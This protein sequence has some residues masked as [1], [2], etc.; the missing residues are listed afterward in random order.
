MIKQSIPRLW[1]L[2]LSVLALLLVYSCHRPDE[3][4]QEY[5]RWSSSDPLAMPYRLRKQRYEQGNLVL[6]S[7]FELGKV[8]RFDTATFTTTLDAWDIIGEHVFWEK[9]PT[10]SAAGSLVTHY[11]RIERNNA[12]ETESFGEGIL[13]DYI[14]VLPGNYELTLRVNLNHIVNP[15]SRTGTGIYDAVDL[16]VLCYDRNKVQLDGQM[17]SP[18][19]DRK[20]DNNFKGV[21]FASFATIDSTGW[22]RIHGKTGDFPFQDGDLQDNARFVRIFI[23]LKGAGTML[24]DD[25]DFRYT[26]Y[27]FTALERI[28]PYFD[29]TLSKQTL[30]LPE[31][32]KME[33]LQSLTYY[34]P[35]YEDNFPIII[36][37]AQC[38]E[39][40]LEAAG[41]LEKKIKQLIHQHTELEE[42]DIPGL[43]HR[44]VRSFELGGALIF[45]IGTTFLTQQYHNEL[46]YPSIANKEKGYFIHSIND[47][48]NIILIDATTSQG[49]VYAIRSCIQLFDRDKL[50]FHNANIIDYPAL[51]HYSLLFIH[52]DSAHAD[53]RMA[54]NTRFEEVYLPASSYISRCSAE[55]D[56]YCTSVYTDAIGGEIRPAD[57]S[58][59]RSA[60]RGCKNWLYFDRSMEPPLP[61]VMATLSSVRCGQGLNA[62]PEKGSFELTLADED[63]STPAPR[64]VWTA[65]G[66]QTWKLDVA[67]WLS[68][69][70]T[71]GSAP[72]FADFSLLAR[73][74]CMGYFAQDSA[75]PYKLKT[76][77]LFDPF[78]NQILPELYGHFNKVI[79]VSEGNSVWDQIRLQTASDFFWNPGAYNPDLSVYRALVNQ[80]GSETAWNLLH[81][82]HYYFKLR[83]EIILASTHRANKYTRRVE[84]FLNQVKGYQEKLTKTA[85]ANS[86]LLQAVSEKVLESEGLIQQQKLLI[87]TP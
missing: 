41:L 65:S 43:I 63:G 49:I 72:V 5:D 85:G 16:K 7:S 9:Q 60:Y 61:E 26:R 83:A 77:C 64:K 35:F 84:E 23:G 40:T 34:R 4:G 28:A 1:C 82:N 62:D 76:A 31:P 80:F 2:V 55:G 87:S 50:V 15:K 66:F 38:D 68:Y 30:V 46:P 48:N 24:V 19:Y 70:N 79:V 36:I 33:V 13:S 17:Y 27:N 75:W 59:I 8:K 57:V 45:S 18:N 25:V 69:S 22:I 78:S 81:F 73:S 53:R 10:D 47:Q 14:K 3:I 67:E 52:P 6:N 37:P 32:Q 58:C 11:I 44:S 54:A 29:T 74:E 56:N 12:S 86:D 71:H 42:K 51:E 21:S 39:R 20:L